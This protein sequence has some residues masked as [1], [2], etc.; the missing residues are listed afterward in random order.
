MLTHECAPL[1]SSATAHNGRLAVNIF[2]RQI[3]GTSYTAS[4]YSTRIGDADATPSSFATLR[5]AHGANE[6]EKLIPTRGKTEF[7]TK[8]KNHFNNSHINSCI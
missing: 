7:E 2:L 6:I 8:P 4:A 3:N 5:F 1:K